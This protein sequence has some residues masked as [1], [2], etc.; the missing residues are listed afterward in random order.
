MKKIFKK[1]IATTLC[2]TMLTSCL[3]GC[4]D[5]GV[6][7]PDYSSNNQR[8]EFLTYRSPNNGKFYIDGLEYYAGETFRTVERYKEMLDCGFTI[9][10]NNEPIEK[11]TVFE[12]SECEMIM[13]RAYEAGFN[14][15][16]NLDKRINNVIDGSRTC[17]DPDKVGV[18]KGYD[19]DP[20]HYTYQSEEQLKEFIKSCLKDY[21][22]MPGFYGL[23]LQDEP[24]RHNADIYGKVYNQTK[25]AAAELGMDEIY[26]HS[27]F[28]PVGATSDH[29]VKKC[30]IVHTN[31]D[32]ASE[33]EF[34][35][36]AENE[37]KNA[38]ARYRD[39]LNDFFT[40]AQ[41][42]R[43]SADTYAFRGGL[44]LYPGMYP[45]LQI[46]REETDKI[47]A[48]LS[49]CLQSF[50]M[51]SGTAEAFRR[52]DQAMMYMEMNSL[53]GFGASNFAY[54]TYCP[55]TESYT[56]GGDVGDGSFLTRDGERTNIWYYGQ[57]LMKEMQEFAPVVLSY[58]FKGAKFVQG[59]KIQY[60]I[61]PYMNG[62]VIGWKEVA[63]DNSHEFNLLKSAKIDNDIALITELKD[64]ENDLYM[65]MVQNVIDPIKGR[66][67][68]T[69]M[70]VEV[71]FGSEY[72]HVAEF[73][74]G[75]LKYV[76]L[77]DGVYKNTLSA[78]YAVYL[79]PLK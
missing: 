12:G 73:D 58:D 8:F 32:P 36:M 51:Y 23:V 76:E 31:E 63:W 2:A 42:D 5:K 78:G 65:Y 39:Y 16:I 7:L 59:D 61:G 71:D 30:N 28:L 6:K 22:D 75:H 67:G 19:P 44:G 55:H 69:D 40:E 50:H 49:Y 17:F 54:Y 64:D 57:Q 35:I 60:G 13:E 52:V 70:N 15:I 77:T 20:T 47:G 26:L 72:T 48:E 9:L 66:A 34:C 14:K 10:Y 56:S 3:A 46:L 25:K 4:G 38:D 68:R 62:E 33:C 79:I 1:I 45:S 29:Y 24:R 53:V 41:F 74:C 18:V 37:T 11:D 21:I 27:N 43:V